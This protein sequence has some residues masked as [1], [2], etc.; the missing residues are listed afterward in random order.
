M[1]TFIISLGG[2]IV[3]DENIDTTFLKNFREAI[4]DFLSGNEGT[5]VLLVVGG[6]FTA[7]KYQ[8]ALEEVKGT[9]TT[10][11]LDLVGI[12]ATMINAEYVR[13]AFSLE[14]KVLYNPR[15]KNI[16][17]HK[18]IAV[19]SG[20]KPGFSTDT[21]A[22]YY[23]LSTGAKTIINLSN[24]EKVYT[25]DPRVDNSATPIDE[26]SWKEF[27]KIVGNKWSAGLNSPFDPIAS[28]LAEK[29][30]LSVICANGKNIY[31]TINILSD[32]DYVGTLIY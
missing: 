28:R 29:N 27:R 14:N 9:V 23:A 3:A 18:N 8:K 30:G 31:N 12:R 2:S 1:R 4:F 24:I 32:R 16:Y 10:D 20:W 15:K 21:D 19:A 26:I 25:S 17:F 7:R 6:G 13:C 11:E 5:R 22:V